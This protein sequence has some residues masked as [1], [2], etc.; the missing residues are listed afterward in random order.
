[1]FHCSSDRHQPPFS[2]SDEPAW[3]NSPSHSVYGLCY[4]QWSGSTRWSVVYCIL[5]VIDYMLNVWS[6]SLMWI[7][8]QQKS[9]VDGSVFVD[10]HCMAAVLAPR[11][12]TNTLIVYSHRTICQ[13]STSLMARLMSIWKVWNNQWR[14]ILVSKDTPLII[15]KLRYKKFPKLVCERISVTPSW[16]IFIDCVLLEILRIIDGPLFKEA[17]LQSRL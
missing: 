15:R 3:S 9:N 2:G 8:P 16:I 1:M 6:K 12:T 10:S 4:V 17:E 11:Q 14:V 5:L 7:L 13:G